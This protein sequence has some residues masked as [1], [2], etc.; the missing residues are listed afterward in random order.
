MTTSQSRN[1][2]KAGAVALS[3]ALAMSTLAITP[4]SAAKK[5][6][7]AKTKITVNVGK[8]KTVKIKNVKKKQVKKLTVKSSKTAVAKAK[9]SK[10][11]AIKVTGKKAGSA[12]VT[13]NLKLKKKVGGKKAYK[14]TLKVTVKKA[15][16]TPTPTVAPTAAPVPVI[17]GASVSLDKPSYDV[18]VNGP[19]QLIT[20]NI[21]PN[22]SNENPTWAVTDS[23]IAAVSGSGATVNGVA[24]ATLT[25]LKEGKT[26][27]TVTLANGQQASAIVNV[28]KEQIFAKITD[29]KQT[30]AN[31]IYVTFDKDART[32]N[33]GFGGTD[34]GKF[35]IDVKN[36][37]GTVTKTIPVNKM[38][39]DT[40]VSGT[41]A[42]LTLDSAFADKD[43]VTVNLYKGDATKA[44]SK[45]FVA[46]VGAPADVQITKLQYQ[47]GVEESVDFA[48]VDAKGIDVTST[49]DKDARITLSAEGSGIASSSLSPASAAKITM[50]TVG[51]TAT[52]NVAYTAA[53]NTTGNPDF[54]KSAVITCIEP[55]A[56]VGKGHYKGDED[57]T[58]GWT[59]GELEVAKF[60][61]GKDAEGVTIDTDSP[62]KVIW[63]YAS[64]EDGEAISYTEYS[65]ASSNGDVVSA[66]SEGEGKFVKI[67]LTGN[68]AGTANI[69]VSAIKN[70]KTAS[71]I[72]P[73]TVRTKGKF[74]SFS[75][76]ASKTSISNA[77]DSDYTGEL[78][79]VAKDSNGK[80]IQKDPD[81]SVTYSLAKP[82]QPEG[83][84]IKVSDTLT[85]ESTG[86]FDVDTNTTGDT[87]KG[88]Y[89]AW[90]AKATSYTIKATATYGDVEKTAQTTV[91]VKSVP[92]AA[93]GNDGAKA[94]YSVEFDNNRKLTED[95]TGTA[96]LAAKLGGVF[97]GYVDA[98]GNIGEEWRFDGEPDQIAKAT[99]ATSISGV[100]ANIKAGSKWNNKDFTTAGVAVPLYDRVNNFTVADSDYDACSAFTTGRCI[101]YSAARTGTNLKYFADGADDIDFAK[102]GN[103]T[104]RFFYYGTKK[105][106]TTGTYE[107]DYST[108]VKKDASVTVKDDMFIPTVSVENRSL[109]DY[110]EDGIKDALKTN[111]DMNCNTSNNASITG[112]WKGYTKRIAGQTDVTMV[113][114]D[115]DTSN[116]ALCKYVAVQEITGGP[117]V[118]IAVGATFSQK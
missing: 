111:V 86:A 80:E 109:T 3:L 39:I 6:K 33:Q 114:I 54:S 5:V 28:G 22:T 70:T 45:D 113:P 72:I 8:T 98:S 50:Q 77:W 26:N 7:L 85:L 46:S 4:A 43:P 25:G 83:A 95:T 68:K 56:V 42:T 102:A 104:I 34:K 58:K 64:D 101:R 12:K 57:K 88:S 38:K 76:T 89:S 35:D 47:N 24:T 1:L 81:F 14:L 23:T 31:E 118:Y 106:S 40:A 69:N 44:S 91:T 27:V 115:T 79:C 20:A 62:D 18:T 13:A 61:K 59:D 66:T 71:Y 15:A 36:A 17:S 112:V 100:Q 32:D 55:V 19:S 21:I 107:P 63:F 105:N 75:I 103:Y 16:A 97:A 67:T 30:K 117:I 93:F 60:Y 2:R 52:L 51:S 29:V 49:I 9:A 92:A 10:K 96:R 11:T 65:V 94:E 82:E 90:G 110:S 53:T 87:W 99:D 116:T 41:A 84:K 108:Y 37:A 73:V 78:T 74:Q 48:V